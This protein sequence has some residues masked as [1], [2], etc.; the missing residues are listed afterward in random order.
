[1][2]MRQL[3]AGYVFICVNILYILTFSMV[4]L[5]TIILYKASPIT[6]AAQQMPHKV[7]A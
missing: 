1:M 4:W 2:F 5:Y 6:L 7:P 3:I